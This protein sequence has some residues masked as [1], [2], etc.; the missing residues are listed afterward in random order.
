MLHRVFVPLRNETSLIIRQFSRLSPATNK[1]DNEMEAVDVK[2][3]DIDFNISNL[4]RRHRIMV[5]GG[6]PPVEYKWE[7]ERSAQRE[8]FGR[9]GMRSGVDIKMLWPTVEEVME[10]QTLRLFREYSDVS[11]ELKVM[12][13]NLKAKDAARMAE[14]E[15]KVAQYPQL[16]AKFEASQ[17][18]AE[19]EKDAKEVALEKRIREIQEYFGYWMDPKDPRFEILMQ[20]K[21]QEE[22]KLKTRSSNGSDVLGM[23]WISNVLCNYSK[24]VGV[25]R[26]GKYIYKP[27]MDKTCCPQYTIRLEV[28]K[29]YLSRNQR[30]VLRQMVEFLKNGMRPR[31]GVREEVD[32]EKVKLVKTGN[33]EFNERADESYLLYVKYQNTVHNDKDSSKAGYKRFLVD[34]PLFNDDNSGILPAFGSYH[35][36]YILDGR[37]IA[38]GVVDI[39]PRC[40]SSKYLFYDPEYSF[41]SLGTYTALREIEFTREL[42][43][44]RP[45]LKYYYMGYY[46]DTC[47]KMRYKGSFRPS[48]LLCDQ[49]LEWV[50]LDECCRLLRDNDSRFT[51]FRPNAPTPPRKTKQDLELLVDGQVLSFD[52]LIYSHSDYSS[53]DSVCEKLKLFASK[54]TVSGDAIA[55]GEQLRL[56]PSMRSRKG[57]SWN[58]RPMV[59]SENFQVDMSFKVSGQGRIGADGMAIWYTAQIGSLGNVFGANDFWTGMGL[60]FDSFDNDGQKNNPQVAL[61]LNDGTRQYDHH[62]DGSQ[63]LLSSCQRDFR[64]KPFPVRVRIE[65]LKNVLTVHVDDG[66]QS[67]PRYELCMRY[68]KIV[69]EHVLVASVFICN[70][71]FLGLKTSFYD[72]DIIDFSVSSLFT[73]MQKPVSAK[74]ERQMKEFEQERAKFKE[75]HPDKVKEDDEFD[76]AK[77]YEDATAREL[78]LIYESQTAIHQVMQQ[79]EQHLQQ[80]QQTQLTQGSVPVQS[81]QTGQIISTGGGF[82]Q[83][84]KNEVMQSLRDLSQSVRDMKQYVNEIFTK[85]YNLEQRW[86][87]GPQSGMELKFDN[88]LSEIR[89]VRANQ[90]QQLLLGRDIYARTSHRGRHII[91][92]NSQFRKKLNKL[93]KFYFQKQARQSEILLGLL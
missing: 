23:L 71:L 3:V 50:P 12:Q 81:D 76:E 62:T 74:F 45:E 27:I 2:A 37:L 22:K 10:E 78:R 83:H 6:I 55:S 67:V 28:T 73:D 77:Y 63:Q 11:N 89:T 35:Q 38:V 92:V 21:E 59:E 43:K 24:W 90:L 36:W 56:A 47:P 53:M 39:L 79:M 26:S 85:T 66:M 9:Y 80:I 15:S 34:S 7:L 8:R 33:E 14:V 4:R 17:V 75:Q 68:V 41:L 44:Q 93:F 58:K 25:G 48:E 51:V 40:V 16:L 82:Q 64:N 52:E 30:R 29:F 54:I 88:L 49:S 31:C 18:K 60:F 87:Q 61:M 46:I 57:I 19:K 70:H 84:E 42:H 69:I 65:Y 32:R 20:Q 5:N 13:E 91:K 1:Q 86:G 72:H